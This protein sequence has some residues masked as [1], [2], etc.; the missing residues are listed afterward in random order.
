MDTTISR[1]DDTWS[2]RTES[3]I[4]ELSATLVCV[5]ADGVAAT[6]ADALRRLG[7]T[8]DVDRA[9]LLERAENS[10]TTETTF[11]WAQPLAPANVDG[12]VALL[13]T[14]VDVWPHDRDA[15]S[16]ARIP[17][18]LDADVLAA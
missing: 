16:L 14:L 13:K 11:E 3:L 6:A 9:L 18:D 15:I 8:L 1:P 4:A 2:T 5:D 17:S 10:V 12:D 7:E